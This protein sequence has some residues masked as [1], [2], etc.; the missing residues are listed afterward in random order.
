MNE[1]TKIFQ[2]IIE[3]Q[4][5]Q[6]SKDKNRTLIF[7]QSL[8]AIDK[9]EMLSSFADE[10][11]LDLELSE[12]IKEKISSHDPLDECQREVQGQKLGEITKIQMRHFDYFSNNVTV[13]WYGS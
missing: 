1:I 7:K 12:K 4:E 13:F 6:I 11:K 10:L 8:N 3:L 5:E 2:K 9:E